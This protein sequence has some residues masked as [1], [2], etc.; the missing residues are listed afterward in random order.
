M[1]CDTIQTSAVDLSAM[2]KLSPELL[3]AALADM[4]L[5]PFRQGDILRFG[6]SEWINIKTGQASL[7]TTRNVNEIKRAYSRQVVM[8]QAKRFGWTLTETKPG[9]FQAIRR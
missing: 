4:G 8:S 3:Q 5:R 6:F 2:G 9:Q 7:T 1:P